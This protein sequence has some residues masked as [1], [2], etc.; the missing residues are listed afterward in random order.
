MKRGREELVE[1]EEEDDTYLPSK[2][3]KPHGDSGER[4][5]CP[6]LDTIKR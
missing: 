1:E 2:A 3:S 5:K 4:I 6:Y